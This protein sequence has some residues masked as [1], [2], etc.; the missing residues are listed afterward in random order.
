MLSIQSYV[1]IG[2]HTIYIYVNKTISTRG[3]GSS[4]HYINLVF[5]FSTPLRV[6]SFNFLN[7]PYLE[8]AMHMDVSTT[9]IFALQDELYS[10]DL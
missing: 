1:D 3:L 4:K 6:K 5:L 2:L 9:C 10:T 8:I 7:D